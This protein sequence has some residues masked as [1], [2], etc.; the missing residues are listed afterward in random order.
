MIHRG[1]LGEWATKLVEDYVASPS[2]SFNDVGEPAWDRPLVGFSSGAD[3]LYDFY[4]RDIGG[5][6]V[7]PA[8]FMRGAH[9]TLE[10]KPEELTVIS[11]VLPQ[12]KATKYDHRKETSMPSERW[13][14][15]RIMGEG[16]NMKLR[17]HV[18][19]EFEKAGYPAVAP[20]LSPLWEQHMSEKYLFASAW[21]ERHAAYA[22]GLGTFGLSDGLITAK[23]KAHRVGS[24]IAKIDIAPTP[25]P[26]TDHHAYCLWYAK[27]TCG[28]C[29]KKCPA[30]AISG[31]GHDKQ[32]CSDYVDTTHAFVEEHFH[33]KGYGCG[34]C[35]VGVP[36]ESRI[37][38]G[39]DV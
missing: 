11:W 22:A 29:I 28:A 37:P 16:V 9:P 15:A 26:Y 36:C 19:E 39:V 24:V 38:E 1:D 35:Q 31:K 4:K 23:G 27:G 8:E 2:N 18:V 5:F 7:L 10:V 6:Y 34:F 32:R 17:A 13:A 25:R 21:S 30:N 3:P 20:M 14:R 33:F 12:T